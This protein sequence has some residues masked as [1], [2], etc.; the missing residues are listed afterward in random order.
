MA[1][2]RIGDADREAGVADLGEHFAQG[3]LTKE[4]Y[5]ERVDAVWSARTRSDLAPV[6]AD[7]PGSA[8]AAG[9]GPRAGSPRPGPVWAPAPLAG[10]LPVARSV[11]WTAVKVAMAALLILTVV[12]HLPF[13]LL[14]A[15]LWF[16]FSRRGTTPRPPWA[17][18]R[19]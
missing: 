3:R 12:T 19:R 15:G 18:Q 2:L 4:E 16:W 17:Q 6:F 7:L 10:R 11:P 9:E 14:A 5:D 8:Y 1:E 13:I